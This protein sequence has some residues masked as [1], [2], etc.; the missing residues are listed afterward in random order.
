MPIMQAMPGSRPRSARAA[1][2]EV[3]YTSTF[4]ADGM[5]ALMALATLP[6]TSAEMQ[7]AP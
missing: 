3:E 7:P 5:F 4:V 2:R 6:H 1:A